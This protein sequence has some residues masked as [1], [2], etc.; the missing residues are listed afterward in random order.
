MASHR[1]VIVPPCFISHLNRVRIGIDLSIIPF[2]R[3][4]SG[5]G[6]E[7]VSVFI[8]NT[9]PILGHIAGEEQRRLHDPTEA[10]VFGQQEQP[11]N[12]YIA[13]AQG[14]HSCTVAI[15]PQIVSAHHVLRGGDAVHMHALGPVDQVITDRNILGALEG[16]IGLMSCGLI[17]RHILLVHRV[18]SHFDHVRS[19]LD[20]TVL[21]PVNAVPGSKQIIVAIP[22][23]IADHFIAFGRVFLF[24]VQKDAGTLKLRSCTVRPLTNIFVG[25]VGP[26]D[27]VRR[28]TVKYRVSRDTYFTIAIL[29]PHLVLPQFLVPNHGSVP[30]G[31]LYFIHFFALVEGSL[32]IF[33]FGNQPVIQEQLHIGTDVAHH[34]NDGCL[35]Q[36]GKAAAAAP[37]GKGHIGC[38]GRS[39]SGNGIFRPVLAADGLGHTAAQLGKTCVPELNIQTDTRTH[40]LDGGLVTLST[41][42]P[43]HRGTHAALA[44]AEQLYAQTLDSFRSLPRL[45]GHESRRRSIGRPVI[46]ERTVFAIVDI[47][48]GG[49]GD[50][51]GNA[52]NRHVIKHSLVSGKVDSSIGVFKHAVA[53]RKDFRYRVKSTPDGVPIGTGG[54]SAYFVSTITIVSTFNIRVCRSVKV[55][56]LDGHGSTRTHYIGSEGVALSVHDGDN[57]GHRLSGVAIDGQSGAG[58]AGGRSNSRTAQIPGTSL[59]LAGREFKAAVFHIG[60]G[61]STGDLHIRNSKPTA[62]TGKHDGHI[63]GVRRGIGIKGVCSGGEIHG[64]VFQRALAAVHKA[65]RGSTTPL[66]FYGQVIGHTPVRGQRGARG[67]NTGIQRQHS[68]SGSSGGGPA[69]GTQIKRAIGNQRQFTQPHVVKP[70]RSDL[71]AAVQYRSRHNRSCRRA[72]A[73]R[74]VLPAAAVSG[75]RIVGDGFFHQHVALVV[76]EHQ[77]D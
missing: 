74:Q 3:I 13:V 57:G 37:Y 2:T 52:V 46:G 9:L 22:F 31:N 41:L 23:Y 58:T 6:H 18:I 73:Y 76:K 65:K 33:A 20:L 30:G 17:G 8:V 44:Q 10:F 64:I 7:R 48:H 71:R 70:G 75:R 72:G 4:T 21:G 26:C 47:L 59:S 16:C 35:I 5:D 51:V 24:P 56:Q 54:L 43:D 55:I 38:S 14:I 42:C 49:V 61:G 19:A 62:A 32:N 67:G 68:V 69:R 39:S 27:S 11:V 15:R 29:M 28:L 25:I 63:C 40:G 53:V 50:R 45:I 77:G 66:P 36:I 60:T 1:T 34:R 12:A